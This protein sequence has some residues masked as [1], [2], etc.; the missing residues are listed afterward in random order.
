MA[1]VSSRSAA[2]SRE[3]L[4]L[5]GLSWAQVGQQVQGTFMLHI[6]PPG[7]GHSQE[8]LGIFR[9]KAA[10]HRHSSNPAVTALTQGGVSM[11]GLYSTD[12]SVRAQQLPTSHTAAHTSSQ[13]GESPKSFHDS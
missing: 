5:E 10:Q 3:Q 6:S 9:K 12:P 4:S 11:M 7:K 13:H 1:T 2:D 8:N